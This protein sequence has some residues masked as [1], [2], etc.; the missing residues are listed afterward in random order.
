MQ[1]GKG[2]Q[3]FGPAK[4]SQAMRMARSKI[5]PQPRGSMI[6]FDPSSLSA[7]E[8]ATLQPGQ[9]FC[10]HDSSGY[11]LALRIATS[12]RAAWLNLSGE[13]SFLLDCLRD[14]LSKLRVLPLPIAASDLRIRFDHSSGSQDLGNHVPGR[15]LFGEAKAHIAT[16]WRGSERRYSNTVECNTWS[17]GNEYEPRFVFERWSLVYRDESGQ[18]V[19][20]VNRV[21]V[22]R[23]AASPAGLPIP[24]AQP[25][26]IESACR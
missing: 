13:D 25:P 14:R 20:V 2:L 18:W 16:Q 5:L 9:L 4:L 8:V 1:R 6:A 15:L 24:L 22:T 19:D 7:T 3:S 12:E 11:K 21:P 23:S 10:Y 26:A 17:T